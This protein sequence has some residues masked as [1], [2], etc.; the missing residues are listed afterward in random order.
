M[1]AFHYSWW[2]FLIAYFIWFSIAP[3]LPEV[4]DTLELD[5]RDIWTTNIVSMVADIFCRFIFGPITDKWGSRLPMVLV[6][7][8]ASIPMAMIGLVNSLA[9][10]I[11]LRF[12]IG[13]AGSAFIMSQCWSTRMF[14]ESI[15]GFT[16]GIIGGWGN[17][18]GG[19]SQIVMGTLLF[20]FF[21]DFVF[22]GTDNSAER[23]WR[24]VGVIPA[25][26]AAITA[27]VVFRTSEDCPEGNYKTLKKEERMGEVSALVSF[28][29]GATNFNT[30]LLYFQYACCAG[31]ELTMNN[32]SVTYFVDHFGLKIASASAISSIFG[33]MNIFARALGGYTSDKFMAKMGMRGRIICQAIIL[34]V[35]GCLIFAFASTKNLGVAIFLLALFSVFVQ[36]AE[37]STYGIV[38]YVNS[39]ATGSVAGIVGAGGPTGAVLF[40]LGFRQIENVK[41]AYFFMAAAVIASGVSCLFLTIKGHRGLLFG[42]DLHQKSV[43]VADTADVITK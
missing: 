9:G 22:A 4:K 18:G 15:V 32:F 38:P 34:I 3:L 28:R 8:A 21:R 25:V 14:D 7:V 42:M 6:L 1:R 26:I 35:E 43:R 23:A 36:A 16:N 39:S 13:I 40:G 41:H 10:L 37:G 12:F 24:T 31:V 11:V 33:F 30:W 20:P 27:V 29:S 2:S 19:L 17:V 5:A